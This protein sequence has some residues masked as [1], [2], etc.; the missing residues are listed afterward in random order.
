MQVEQKQYQ[1]GT[2]AHRTRPGFSRADAAVPPTK[3]IAHSCLA[4]ASRPSSP[5]SPLLFKMQAHPAPARLHTYHSS[6][7]QLVGAQTHAPPAWRTAPGATKKAGAGP[8]AAAA[9]GS[10]ILLSQLPTDVAENEVEV[11]ALPAFMQHC[12]FAC[13]GEWVTDI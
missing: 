8:A 3:S 10:K 1:E 5:L 2:T 11:R 6:K 7:R 12:K 9:K 13:Y 4:P